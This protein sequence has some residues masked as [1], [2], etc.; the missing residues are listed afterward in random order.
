VSDKAKIWLA[1]IGLL[2]IIGSLSHR[3]TTTTSSDSCEVTWQKYHDDPK[4]PGSFK[5]AD[6]TYETH[7]EWI[8]RC[9]QL[10]DYLNGK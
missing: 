5:K 8:A 6:G 3:G 1:V 9:H 10:G 4:S 7:S 2:L